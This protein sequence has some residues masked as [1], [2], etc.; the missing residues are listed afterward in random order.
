MVRIITYYTKKRI[1]KR[2][3]SKYVNLQYR[4]RLDKIKANNV[5]E[6]EIYA[7]IGLLILF[8]LT[9][10][11]DIS[12]ELLWSDKSFVHFTPFASAA[13][14]RERYQLISRYICFDD[15]DTRIHR[16]SNKF[17]KMEAIFNLFKKNLLL[18]ISSYFLC[19][20]Y[21]ETLYPFRGMCSFR[22]YIPSKP[23]RYGIKF[24]SLVDVKL[25]IFCDQI[26]FKRYLRIL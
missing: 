12:I 25:G 23:A 1:E 11:N 3:T 14:S 16:E 15:I 9:N 19:I 17:H 13:M 10:K 26:I 18:I 7:Y 20:T 5:T 2:I 24:W 4:E 6:K 8:G 21:Y 22:Q